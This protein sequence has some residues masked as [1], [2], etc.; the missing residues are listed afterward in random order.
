MT[1]HER[2]FKKMLSQNTGIDPN[3]HC[4]PNNV[5]FNIMDVYKKRI[6]EGG[7]IKAFVPERC[8]W[9]DIGTLEKYK[10]AVIEN[11][12]PRVFKK[13]WTDHL[14]KRMESIR[15]KVD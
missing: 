6:A 4:I 9:E 14:S 10:K 2:S 12:A 5:F 8:Y 13:I 3:S 7:K 1:D 11:M 15:L